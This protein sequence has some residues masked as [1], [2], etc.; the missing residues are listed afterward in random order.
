MKTK[1]IPLTILLLTVIGSHQTSSGQ[2]LSRKTQYEGILAFSNTR[3]DGNNEI[4]TVNSDGTE[5]T[6][7]TNSTVRDLGPAWSPDGSKIAF[8]IHISDLYQWSEYIM[9]ADGSNI[10]R[11]T[12]RTNVCDGQPDWSP[13]GRFIA[14]GRLYSRENYRAEVW[15]MNADG[16]NQHRVGT[17][18]GDSPSWSPDGT[19]MVFTYHTN[20]RTSIAIVNADGTGLTEISTEGTENWWPA[21]SPD[22]TKIAF[23]SN[24][25]GN[26]E[27]FVMNTDGSNP[28]KLTD[29]P[30]ED[31]DPAWSPDGSRIA[32]ISWRNE[33]YEIHL[34]NADGTSPVRLITMPTHNIQPAWKPLPAS[35]TDKPAGTSG[36]FLEQN[37]PNPAYSTTTFSFKTDKTGKVRLEV[38]DLSG[39]TIKLILDRKVDPGA[40]NIEQDLSS[41]TAGEYIYRLESGSNQISKRLVKLT[42]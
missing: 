29:N 41:L 42:N 8:Y 24:R 4:Y 17:F 40:Y 26:H 27:L 15:M 32:Y 5:F 35:S 30:G 16:T 12:D 20:N 34:I 6:R 2:D 7:I 19:K 11:L 18:N 36:L 1:V 21:W 9:D 22:G 28:V 39:K 13:D 31:G 37:Y 33:R 23:Q 10:K 14:F 38:F 3:P 25:T